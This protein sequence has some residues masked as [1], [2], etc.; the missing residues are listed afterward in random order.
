MD[1]INS[2]AGSSDNWA[3]QPQGT[4][5][6]QLPDDS[7]NKRAYFLQVFGRPDSASAC[8]CER[9]TSASLSQSLML[10]NSDDVQNKLGA[11]HGIA[12]NFTKDATKSLAEMLNQIYLTAYARRATASEV[13]LAE[14]YL[15]KKSAADVNGR[16]T[17]WEDL[18][19]AV[20]SSKEF[21]F[22]H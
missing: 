7:Y 12:D 11:P 1:A 5:A 9:Q 18:L 2:V 3:N 22:N 20:M 14:V 17:A 10:A 16:K 21:L 15:A 6:V 13:Q 19:W 4:R 8:A